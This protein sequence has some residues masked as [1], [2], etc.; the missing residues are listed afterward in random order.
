ML[1]FGI[2][3]ISAWN[4]DVL[5]LVLE[6]NKRLSLN[7]ILLFSFKREREWARYIFFSVTNILKTE[8]MKGDDEITIKPLVY[9]SIHALIH[10]FNK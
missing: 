5:A 7:I 4:S 6:Y 9:F 2:F 10:L 8:A 1:T 3:K